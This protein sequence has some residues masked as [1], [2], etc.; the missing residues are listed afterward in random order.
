MPVLLRSLLR[1]GPLNPIAVRLVQTGSARAKHM[2]LRAGYLLTLIAVL[3]LAL[4]LSMQGDQMSFRDL[5]Q[6]GAATFSYVAYLQVA[7]ICVLAPVF[8][9]GAIAQESDPRT[10]DILLTT[11]LSASEVVMGNLMG[12][13]F[14]ILAL[15]M[16]SLPLFAVTQYF[17]GVPGWAIAGSYLIA[18]A[19][20]LVV[21]SSAVA[22]SVSRAV[23]RRAV[24]TFYIGVVSFLAITFAGDAVMR[25]QGLGAGL[26]GPNIAPG[27]GVT[28]FT[29]F[30]P[31]LALRAMLEPTAYPSDMPATHE[32]LRAWFYEAPTLT[33]LLLSLGLSLGLIVASIITVRVGGIAGVGG[34]TGRDGAAPRAPWYRRALGLGVAGR[35][36]GRHVWANPI[37]WREAASRNAT[38][39]RIVARWGF[40]ALGLL[41]GLGLTL[42]LH[43]RVIP[44]ETFRIAL[45][46]TVVGEL[47]I[48]ALV[49]IN[50]SASSISKEREDGTLDLLLTTPI[51]ATQYVNGKLRG[52]VA[53]L[54]PLLCVPLITLAFAGFYA[55]FIA[56][57]SAVSSGYGFGMPYT[58]AALGPSLAPV[59]LGEALIVVPLVSIPFVA[60]CVTVGMFISLRSAGVLGAVTATIASLGVV[61]TLVGF[62][63][64]KS[65]QD[66]VILGPALAA[67]SPV[68]AALSVV[69][70][71]TSMFQTVSSS[72]SGAVGL[73]GARVALI[74]GAVASALVHTGVVWVFQSAM[75]RN[76]DMTVRKLAG[77]R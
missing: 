62:C 11:P 60:V 35:R 24:F 68:T 73:T 17:G 5:A 9:S 46:A 77:A 14:F 59:V 54:L 45:L 28:W 39:G 49:A 67:F 47:V 15:L 43:L 51:T 6:A 38:L 44:P 55:S 72:G 7:L 65:A 36:A 27:A 50:L 57:P 31:F 53:Y 42:L 12:R 37:A 61:A 63:G 10:W 64:W 40:I 52:L 41:L 22:L 4:L 76:F 32:G 18:G 56:P 20:A 13:L 19:A 30:N 26:G 3:M 33:F 23:G 1:L 74:V 69:Y 8:M 66:I 70:P 29:A 2:Y 75:V 21:G 34:L 71:E 58:D 16:S 25:A 48:I